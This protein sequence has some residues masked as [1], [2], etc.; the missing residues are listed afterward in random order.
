VEGDIHDPAS[1]MQTLPTTLETSLRR[2]GCS[3]LLQSLPGGPPRN[4]KE[5]IFSASFDE[6]RSG[7]ALLIVKQTAESALIIL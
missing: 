1:E 5:G 4:R 3:S 6:H 7:G 2:C